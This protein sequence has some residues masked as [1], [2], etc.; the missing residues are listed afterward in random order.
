MSDLSLEQVDSARFA[1]LVE[2]SR[3]LNST[4]DL[5]ELLDFIIREAAALTGTEAA[6]IM[7]LDAQTRELR[8]AAASAQAV[9]ELA[10]MPV[11]LDDS[12]AG[13]VFRTN[14]PLIVGDVA[15]EPRWNSQVDQASGF[16]TDSILGVPMHNVAGETV[17]VLEALNK[18]AGD[19]SQQDVETLSTLADL[20]G[21]AVERARLVSELREA[22]S[23]LNELDQLKSK[24]IAV[25]SHELRT[26]LS[27]IL[28]YLSFLREKADNPET[29]AQLDTVLGAAVRLRGLIEDMLNL[30]YVERGEPQLAAEPI[31]FCAL[32]RHLIEERRGTMQAKKLHVSLHLPQA[33]LQIRG[34]GQAMETVVGNLLNNAI[35]FTQLGGSIDVVLA[36]HGREA[37]LEV[38]DDGIG[39]P[40][41]K[42]EQV[43]TRF[44]QVEP[45]LV[46]S[47]EGLGLGLAVA[48]DLLEAQGGRIWVRS[49]K[50]E[51]SCFYVA[52]PLLTAATR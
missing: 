24:F 32:V 25:A 12:V 1:R 33:P 5:N 28:G 6:S 7:L 17:G 20:A 3:V 36:R 9:E 30:Q 4:S 23:Q 43:F 46:R 51:G 22:Y 52:M 47:Y 10:G 48:R 13:T 19:F 26:P 14:E 40:S 2:A 29:V 18:P 39:I 50:G 37:W 45:P 49:E 41:D 27:I 38:R 34:D 35:K 42:L 31:D 16:R 15:N 21:V 44:Y 8:F 11:G